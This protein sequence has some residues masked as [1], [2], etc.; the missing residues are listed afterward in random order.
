MLS[1]F[2]NQTTLAGYAFRPYEE[3]W[4]GEHYDESVVPEV[5]SLTRAIRELFKRRAR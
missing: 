5:L 1:P 2:S 3:R 4:H